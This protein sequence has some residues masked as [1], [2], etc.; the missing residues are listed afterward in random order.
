MKPRIR[1]RKRSFHVPNFV[2]GG[3]FSITKRKDPVPY[4]STAL[5]LLIGSWD[6]NIIFELV[7]PKQMEKEKLSYLRYMFQDRKNIWLVI[8]ILIFTVLWLY[9]NAKEGSFAQTLPF[10]WPIWGAWILFVVGTYVRWRRK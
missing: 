1:F 7:K 8:F 10:S 3:Y 2:L 4:F 9:I 6:L 5:N